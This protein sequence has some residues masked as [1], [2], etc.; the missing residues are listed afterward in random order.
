MLTKKDTRTP[1][2]SSIFKTKCT[3]VV[4][5]AASGLRMKVVVVVVVVVVRMPIA[6]LCE[7]TLG[8]LAH[9]R[10]GRARV[11]FSTSRRAPTAKR[12]RDP[13]VEPGG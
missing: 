9:R 2:R 12:P 3:L 4:V 13:P 11:F 10:P 1:E 6:E 7:A 8:M 5:V